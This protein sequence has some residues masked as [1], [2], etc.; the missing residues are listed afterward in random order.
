MSVF[1][2]LWAAIEKFYAKLRAEAPHLLQDFDAILV[3][4]H[5]QTPNTV[6]AAIGPAPAAPGPVVADPPA[7]APASPAPST[8]GD[9]PPAAAPA[10]PVDTAADDQNRATA[11]FLGG[12]SGAAPAPATS[13]PAQSA[14]SVVLLPGIAYY[15]HHIPE[16]TPVGTSPSFITTEPLK[17]G[18]VDV[19]FTYRGAGVVGQTGENKLWAWDATQ[20]DTPSGDLAPGNA[21]AQ[22]NVSLKNVSAGEV[23]KIGF[24]GDMPNGVMDVELQQTRVA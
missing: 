11:A 2:S 6:P 10:A 1:T 4:L 15:F 19:E 16:G 12:G 22:V 20:S 3:E 8:A 5:L 9:T 13:A 14:P 24:Y 23:R 21:T 7:Q 17:G 18:D